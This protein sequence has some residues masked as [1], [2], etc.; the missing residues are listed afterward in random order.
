M[1]SSLSSYIKRPFQK[2]ILHMASCLCICV[3]LCGCVGSKIRVKNADLE[4]PFPSLNDVPERPREDTQTLEDRRKTIKEIIKHGES[5][6]VI[7]APAIPNKKP[8]QVDE[9]LK[10]NE[11]LRKQFGL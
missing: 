10:R 5:D 7:E 3:S 11:D 4:A 1:I 8:E 9:R 6:A 2:H